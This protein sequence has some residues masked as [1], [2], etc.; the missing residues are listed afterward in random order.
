MIKFGLVVL[1]LLIGVAGGLAVLGRIRR[2]EIK[3]FKETH[4]VAG[5]TDAQILEGVPAD[6]VESALVVLGIA[7]E[8]PLMLAF[9]GVGYILTTAFELLGRLSNKSIL[10]AA[11]S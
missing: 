9:F 2:E 5:M 3:V 10:K 7:V 8:W 1:Y 4:D 11:R 6:G